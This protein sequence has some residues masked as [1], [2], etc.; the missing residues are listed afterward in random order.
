MVLAG[1]INPE[2]ERIFGYKITREPKEAF[3]SSHQGG[4]MFNITRK[5]RKML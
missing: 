1:R 4:W 3:L 5:L 2:T